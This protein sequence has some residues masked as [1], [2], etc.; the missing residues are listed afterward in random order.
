MSPA[1]QPRV[2]RIALIFYP[3]MLAGLFFLKPPGVLSTDDLGRLA[4]GLGLALAAGW[5]VV[6]G[7]RHAARHTAWGRALRREF[8]AVLGPLTSGETLLLALLSAFGEEILFRGVLHPRL[9]LWPTALLFGLFP[10][11]IRRELLPWSLF[12]FAMGAALGFLTDAFAALWPAILLHFIVN[13][14]NLRDLAEPDPE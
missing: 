7:S 12:A 8:R 4:A 10:F 14:R 11:P 2:V 9:G 3:P 5:T 1:P 6:A 13:Y